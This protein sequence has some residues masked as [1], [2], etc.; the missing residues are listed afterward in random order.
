MKR[1]RGQ[2]GTHGFL[3]GQVGEWTSFNE[4][5]IHEDEQV[6]DSGRSGDKTTKAF[7]Q[8]EISC[9]LSSADR[10]QNHSKNVK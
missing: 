2:D 10:C 5:E 1:E 7:Q 4:M 6:G 8:H 3:F 9:V